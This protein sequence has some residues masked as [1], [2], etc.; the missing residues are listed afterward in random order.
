LRELCKSGLPSLI[1]LGG[2]TGVGKTTIARIIGEE[3][4]CKEF[5]ETNAA[6]DGGIDKVRDVKRDLRSFPLSGGTRIWY[7]DEVHQS[8]RQFQEG[9][10]KETEDTLDH[11][12]FIFSSSEPDK[13]IAAIKNRASRF[14]LKPLSK[15]DLG[16]LIYNVIAA[17]KMRF[18]EA[19]I[20]QI[21]ES[22]EGSARQALVMLEQAA[23][24]GDDKAALEVV[25]R[26]ASEQEGGNFCKILLEGSWAK[27]QKFLKGD[28][29]PEGLRRGVMA[30]MA[31]G[32]VEDW[33]KGPK[34]MKA[35]KALRL[36]QYLFQ[37]G[38]PDLV[39][40]TWEFFTLA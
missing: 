24:A 8:S 33:L 3:L 32:L 9:L 5:I 36:F 1:L 12:K 16:T 23:A 38:K 22:A 21:V 7:F 35:A 20:D 26:T 15:D 2:P 6:T 40:C 4:G 29:D 28:V 34:E 30:Y 11:D 27:A 17:E 31:K 25:K 14:D 10:L 39:R 19:V 37:N 13:L 18:G